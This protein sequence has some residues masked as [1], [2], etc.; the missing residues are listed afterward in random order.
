MKINRFAR[1]PGMLLVG[2][3]FGLALAAGGQTRPEYNDVDPFSS[4]S[5]SRI[6]RKG[7]AAET[8]KEQKD[9][10]AVMIEMIEVDHFVLNQMI[11]RYGKKANDVGE[12][13]DRLMDMVFKDDAK[14]LETLWGRSPLGQSAAVESVVEK[15]YP[16]EYEPPALPQVVMGGNAEKNKAE[17]GKVL[18]ELGGDLYTSATPTDFDTRNVG[19]TFE[20]EV[21]ESA[22]QPGNFAISL[23]LSI[24]KLLQMDSFGVEGHE[25]KA[26]G[27]QNIVMPRFSSINQEFVTTVKLGNYT[28]LG[29]FKEGGDLT[30]SKRVVVL[31]HVDLIAKE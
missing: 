28:L 26:R 8:L 9:Q 4:E 11:S 20:F 2:L 15:I 31:M 7:K 30:E 21:V 10:V 13:H 6:F 22:D 23:Y 5:N 19:T 12:M 16:T 25:D 27:T 24:V 17:V 14:L 18:M 1:K 29:V 3:S